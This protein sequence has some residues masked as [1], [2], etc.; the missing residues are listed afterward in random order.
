MSCSEIFGNL[1]TWKIFSKNIKKKTR[2][3]ASLFLLGVFPVW[4]LRGLKVDFFK[5]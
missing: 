4:E 5:L 3:F 1:Q 2:M